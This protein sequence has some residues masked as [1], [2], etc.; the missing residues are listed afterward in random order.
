M[1]WWLAQ[2]A[3]VA[4]LLTGF[5]ALVCR[6]GRFRPAVRHALWLVVMVKLVT[7]PCIAWPWTLPAMRETASAART[8][9]ADGASPRDEAPPWLGEREILVASD[10]PSTQD[11]SP[12]LVLGTAER[13]E[14]PPAIQQVDS[15]AWKLGGWLAPLLYDLW[16]AGTALVCLLQVVRIAR[17]E[18]L[19]AT[20][21]PGPRWLQKLVAEVAGTLRVPRPLTCVVPGI[22]SPCVWGVG[23]PKL[24]WPASLLEHLPRSCRRSIV[25][26]ELAHLRRRDHWVGWLQLVAECLWW[27]NPLFWYVRRQLR[28]NAELAC[29][30][31]VVSTL[32]EDRRAYAEALIEVTQLI[33][34]TAAP[35]PAL[36]M[37]SVA[38]H[39]FERR[40][41]MIMRERV[42][43]RVPLVGLLAVGVL[44]L[45]ALPGW[46]QP[47]APVKLALDVKE[48]PAPEKQVVVEVRTDVD[49]QGA[50]PVL[51]LVEKTVD[52][53][54]VSV[55][56]KPD[57]APDRDR[58][59]EKLEAQLQ[60]LLKEVQALRG[61]G[62]K[63]RVIYKTAPTTKP[64]GHCRRCC[65]TRRRR[66]R[67]HSSQGCYH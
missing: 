13:V 30:A 25:A 20:T 53:V 4:G 44:G 60:E 12:S 67:P 15:V 52:G 40:L 29:D 32:P 55:E 8:A 42:P 54:T 66:R 17:F 5:V 28:R 59:L 63:P 46:S 26:H 57:A 24:V 36:G 39:D 33:S 47:G 41:T 23:R 1:L 58:R 27:W 51:E 22:G 31:W 14:E 49:G 38:R 50:K 3:L 56:A 10:A 7:P 21:A 6:F 18:R 16:L 62:P 34:Q 48:A 9:P 61:G 37:S 11:E 19:L 35:M 2:N 64:P 65:P 43:C 45:L